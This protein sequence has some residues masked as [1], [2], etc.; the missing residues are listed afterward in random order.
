[1]SWYLANT[2]GVG[3]QFASGHG[4][5]DLRR[6]AAP[7]SSLMHFINDGMT[8]NVDVCESQLRQLAER[9]TDE[10]V[11]NTAIGLADLMKGQDLVAITQGF[12]APDFTDPERKGEDPEP[13]IPEGTVAAQAA[14]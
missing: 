1:M 9:T 8:K 10:D 5:A 2:A 3:D 4:L 6:A 14:A 13:I 11:R 12:G 7:Y